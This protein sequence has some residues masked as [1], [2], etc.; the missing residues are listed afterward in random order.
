MTNMPG[1]TLPGKAELLAA[2]ASLG[3][4]Y[5]RAAVANYFSLSC[6]GDGP[7]L[8]LDCQ[9]HWVSSLDSHEEVGV[10]G[11]SKGRQRK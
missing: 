11:G 3:I 7:T 1:Y 5:T 6:S 8:H 2:S 10:W 9:E 4:G